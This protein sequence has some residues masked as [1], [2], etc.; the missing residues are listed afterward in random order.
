MVFCLGRAFLRWVSVL[1]KKK[2]VT[3]YFFKQYLF[4]CSRIEFNYLSQETLRRSVPAPCRS[5]R[6]SEGREGAVQLFRWISGSLNVRRYEGG[7]AE[8][9]GGRGED[10]QPNFGYMCDGAARPSSLWS[11]RPPVRRPRGNCG[12]HDDCLSVKPPCS[13]PPLPHSLRA[14]IFTPSA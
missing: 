3:L 9:R 12:H 7:S 6:D 2:F 11:V 4:S 10:R 13:S 1:R 5:E 14:F 8:R